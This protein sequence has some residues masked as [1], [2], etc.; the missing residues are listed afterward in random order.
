M[1]ELYHG[2]KSTCS[3]KVRICMAEKRLPVKM[4]AL[5]LMKFEQ[6]K[7][8]YLKLNP[9]G[10]VPTLVHDGVAVTE[11]TVINEYLDDSFPEMP[12]R[13]NHPVACA[14][15]R[16]WTKF[17]DDYALPAVVVPTWTERIK[18]ALDGLSEKEKKERVESVP[19]RDRR[20]RYEILLHGGFGEEDFDA[21]FD[22]FRLMFNKMEDSLKKHTWLSGETFSLADVNIFPYVYRALEI[23]DNL[24]KENMHPYTCRWFQR[25]KERHWYKEIFEHELRDNWV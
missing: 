7:P 12:L 23:D 9:N 2:W 18:K 22:T 3:R 5:N 24:L 6:H 19:L 11:S 14:R 10:Y 4:H 21:A 8:E 1:L 15:M 25:M 13:P 16:I 17:V 20:H